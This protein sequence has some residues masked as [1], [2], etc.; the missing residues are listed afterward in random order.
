MIFSSTGLVAASKG[1]YLGR[2]HLTSTDQ[3]GR[4]VYQHERG[5]SYLHYIDDPLH[6]LQAWAITEERTD[7][8]ADLLSEGEETCADAASQNW[9]VFTGSAWESDTTAKVSC[10][11]SSS[12]CCNG[13]QLQSTGDIATHFPELLDTYRQ[14]GVINGRPSYSNGEHRVFFYEDT[15]HHLY[16]WTVTDAGSGSLGSLLAEGKEDCAE[17]TGNRWEYILDQ[18]AGWVS[19]STFSAS[20]HLFT[21]CCPS[22]TVSSTG[23]AAAQFPALLGEYQ[24]TAEMDGVPL[25]SGPS[26]AKFMYKDDLLHK[27]SGWVITQGGGGLG[28]IA[29]EASQACPTSLASTWEVWQ[30]GGWVT[31]PSLTIFCKF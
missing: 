21:D 30:D 9:E 16:G 13:L 29:Q 18:G 1:S 4:S 2:Y 19:D 31:D 14:E 24:K 17:D 12:G 6:R 25:Y 7:S 28:S 22:L 20:C 15:L 11:Q 8:V 3:T 23:L 27:W 5:T 10:D 26:G